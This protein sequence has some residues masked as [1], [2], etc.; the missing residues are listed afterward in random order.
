MKTGKIIKALPEPKERAADPTS[1]EVEDLILAWASNLQRIG[2]ESTDYGATLITLNH[3]ES[4]YE[5][6][7]LCTRK[8]DE[9]GWYRIIAPTSWGPIFSAS[10]DDGI[11]SERYEDGV[12]DYWCSRTVMSKLKT[13]LD[14]KKEN[15]GQ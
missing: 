6:P 14:N 7:S 10:N 15:D 4:Q 2:D 5:I 13:W 12:I 1:K 8:P 3:N 9:G 11:K